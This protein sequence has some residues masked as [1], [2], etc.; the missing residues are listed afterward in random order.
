MLTGQPPEFDPRSSNPFAPSPTDHGANPIGLTDRSLKSGRVRN[1]LTLSAKSPP[2]GSDK[3]QQESGKE[4]DG[5]CQQGFPGY[6]HA[7]LCAGGSK[8]S[9]AVAVLKNREGTA[10]MSQLRARCPGDPV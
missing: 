1:F 8:K 4:E 3:R 9:G 10:P 7:T 5:R 6:S 2:G